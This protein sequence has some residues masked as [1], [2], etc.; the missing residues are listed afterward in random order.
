MAVFRV[1]LLMLAL[2]LVSM[3]SAISA[4]DG[5]ASDFMSL[6]QVA[7]PL[8][9]RVTRP[10]DLATGAPLYVSFRT[11][12]LMLCALTTVPLCPGSISYVFSL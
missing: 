4:S 3:A 1:V 7:G 5:A 2:L 11:E 8:A 10:R 6:P 12:I 9:K